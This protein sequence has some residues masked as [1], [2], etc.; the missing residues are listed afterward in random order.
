[1]SI[2]DLFRVEAESEEEAESILL[3]RIGEEGWIPYNASVVEGV[4][5]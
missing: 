3:D 4:E 2:E 5:E 1:M